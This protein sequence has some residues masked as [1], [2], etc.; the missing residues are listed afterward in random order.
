MDT[1]LG[2]T[3]RRLREE[4]GWSKTAL[5]RRAG[6]SSG[7]ISRLEKDPDA[8]PSWRT[9]TGLAKAFSI[10]VSELTADVPRE[11]DE[12]PKVAQ[13]VKGLVHAVET[14]KMTTEQALQIMENLGIIERRPARTR[15]EEP[16]SKD[17]GKVG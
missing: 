6:I 4:R 9:L 2:D 17:E 10:T 5:A 15:R 8:G 16:V 7:E 11:P 3:I 12:D 13:Q 14:G 1:A